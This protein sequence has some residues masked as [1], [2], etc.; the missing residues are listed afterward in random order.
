MPVRKADTSDSKIKAKTYFSLFPAMSYQIPLKNCFTLV[1]LLCAAGLIGCSHSKTNRGHLF[2]CDWAFEYNRTPWIGC[3]ADSGIDEEKQGCGLFDCFRKEKDGKKG[4]RRHCGQTPNCT[5]QNPCCRTL[6]CGM[7]VD[8]AETQTAMVALGGTAKACGLT[9][10]CSPQKPCGLTPHC[11]KPVSV[12]VHPQTLLLN[13]QTG[14]AANGQPGGGYTVSG[15]PGATL[16]GLTGRTFAAGNPPPSAGFA[17]VVRG[18]SPGGAG[19]IESPP[20]SGGM[21][22]PVPLVSRG[23]VPGASLITNNGGV[24]AAIGVATPAG[25]MTASGLRMGNGIVNPNVVLRACAMTP[26]CT[27]ARPCGLTPGCGG[28]VALNSVANNAVGLASALQA[29]GIASGVMQASGGMGTL[30]NPMTNQPVSGVTMS[31]YPQQGYPPI[32]YAPTGYAPGYPRYAGGAV[33]GEEPEE[34]ETA[35]TE[36]IVPEARSKM[37]VSRFQPIPSKPVFQRSEGMKPTPKPQ[38]AVKPETAA[39]GTAAYTAAHEA[40]IEEQLDRAYLEGVAAAMDEVERKIEARQQAAAK[41]ELQAKILRQSAI[42]EQQFAVQ[43][44]EELPAVAAARQRAAQP[45]AQPLAVSEPKRLPPPKPQPQTAQ[46]EPRI[47]PPAA[48]APDIKPEK[49][50]AKLTSSIKNTIAAEIGTLRIP[51]L[52]GRQNQSQE[53]GQT[54]GHKPAAA[55]GGGQKV[56]TEQAAVRTTLPPKPPVSEMRQDYGLVSDEE[57]DGIQQAE[58]L[59]EMP[60]P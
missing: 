39:A 59:A 7:W 34:T 57:P 36:E 42:M 53:T 22:M 6:G 52:G 18:M 15:V 14:G 29:Q 11:G 49:K 28:A 16:N 43:E 50:L 20:G 31:G 24:V 46:T 21:P 1:A 26:N 48:A 47:P 56:R 40:D 17:G 10:F 4:Y 3:P 9:P 19:Y 23:I 60:L 55:A 35:E 58:F 25:T 2:R 5:A 33:Q 27:A 32:G 8:P 41:A 51:I 37:P 30:V 12:N 54:A 38:R 45:S 44:A 13:G